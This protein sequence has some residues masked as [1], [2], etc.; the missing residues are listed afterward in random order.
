M[1]G[2]AGWQDGRSTRPRSPAL[3]RLGGVRACG[4]C[5]WEGSG[6]GAGGACACGEVR[7]A[8]G[9]GEG[10]QQEA[11]VREDEREEDAHRREVTD[12]LAGRA[13][14]AVALVRVWPAAGKG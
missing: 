7:R 11:Q 10:E 6:S 1:T 4:V 12:R 9:E 5:E 2:G 13:L 8:P 14:V 3:L